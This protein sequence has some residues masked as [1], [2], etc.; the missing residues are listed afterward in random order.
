MLYNLQNKKTVLDQVKIDSVDAV[1]LETSIDYLTEKINN[2]EEKLVNLEENTTTGGGM[3]LLWTNQ[4]PSS[5]FAAQTI[6]IDLSNYDYITITWVFIYNEIEADYGSFMDSFTTHTTSAHLLWM[7][8]SSL[9]SND[10]CMMFRTIVVN[11]SGV[12]F[13]DTT[14]ICNGMTT[15]NT[16]IIPIRIY[17]GK[18]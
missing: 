14:S 9:A 10:L 11:S 2:L 7:R 1:N 17:G 3:K 4:S 15:K 5:N 13:S 12:T 16:R 8:N 18:F 6:S